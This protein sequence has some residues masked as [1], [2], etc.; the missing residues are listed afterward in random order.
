MAIIAKK[1]LAKALLDKNT[2]SYANRDNWGA[3]TYKD[4][5]HDFRIAFSDYL[6][7]FDHQLTDEELTLYFARDYYKKDPKLL[8]AI[9]GKNEDQ[10][11]ATKQSQPIPAQVRSEPVPSAAPPPPRV[12]A[13]LKSG[14]ANT[15]SALGRAFQR[16]F[17]KH[18]TFDRV[19][20]GI[21]G[22]LGGIGGGVISGGN[23]LMIAAG[24]GTGA[25]G[26]SY[27][28]SPEGRRSLG[29]AGN[30]VINTGINLSNRASGNSWVKGPSKRVW[31]GA[32]VGFFI[33]FFILGGITT[34]LPISAPTGEAAPVPGNVGVGSTAAAVNVA[35]PISKL[36]CTTSMSAED[37]DKFFEAKGYYNFA[38]TGAVF[39]SASQTYNI[40]PALIIAIGIQESSLGN[41]YKDKST[42]GTKNA[43]GLMQKD[44]LMRFN[45]WSDGIGVA[46]KTVASFKCSNIE[47]IGNRYAPINASNDPNNLNKNWAPG[48]ISNLNS[49]PQSSCTPTA[50]AQIEP[51]RP[52]GWPT[53]GIITQGP[54]GTFSHRGLNAIDISN[55]GNNVPVYSTLGGV[56][57]GP[58]LDPTGYGVYVTVTNEQTKAEVL[59]GHLV[60]GSNSHLVKG[61]KINKGDRIG[62]MDSTGYSTGSH[63]HYEIRGSVKNE[64]LGQFIPGGQATIQT[65]I[66]QAGSPLNGRM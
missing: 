65:V 47:C 16:N 21:F 8:E 51:D 55:P 59:F 6:R 19:T 12:P 28:T 42:E 37:I 64:S 15:G 35:T 53:T 62:I 20:T 60:P 63:L 38:G 7:Q 1:I 27:L 18:L 9:F 11:T 4:I 52:S 36:S 32:L 25:V 3:Y 44:S 57:S 29:N 56:T 49:I 61:Q 14:L 17:G 33:L 43:F 30:K 46:F 34:G 41:V 66:K 58:L 22:V 39:A 54:F 24:A 2:F 31:I 50:V 45:S 23:P 48:V 10:P 5:Y 13:A 40:N 26:G